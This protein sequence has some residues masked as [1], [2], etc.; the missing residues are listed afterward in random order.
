M[1]IN[2]VK[3]HLPPQEEGHHDEYNAKTTE[4]DA[5]QDGQ[6]IVIM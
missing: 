2:I 4:D 1:T 6:V 5:N 3:H